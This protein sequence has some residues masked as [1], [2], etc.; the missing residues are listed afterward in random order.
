MPMDVPNRVQIVPAGYEIERIVEPATSYK[1]DEVILLY[2]LHDDDYSQRC[3]EL[4]EGELENRGIEFN[5]ITTDLFDL[6]DSLGAIAEQIHKRKNDNVFVNLATGT[7]VTAIAG[8]IASMTLEAKPYYVRVDNYRDE[9]DVNGD[10]MSVPTSIKDVFDLPTYPIDSPETQEVVIMELIE[11]MAKNDQRLTKGEII[12]FGEQVGL[13]FASR[14][15]SGKG[16]YR[17]LD[18]EVL[19]PLSEQNY[20]EEISSG[21]NKYVTLTEEGESA[22]AAF[23][24]VSSGEIDVEKQA[25]ELFLE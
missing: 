14:D 21:R 12:H 2:H 5:I 9:V 18:S 23:R 19:H 25:R 4:V 1:A 24:W 13:E 15:V 16:K 20:I 17:T 22:L 11:F 3:H 7:K 8:M 6:Y 10:K